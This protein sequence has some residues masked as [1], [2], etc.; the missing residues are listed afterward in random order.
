MDS[1]QQFA[2]CRYL[3]DRYPKKYKLIEL[4]SEY[5]LVQNISQFF[6][7]FKYQLELCSIKKD[8]HLIKW[9]S[10]KE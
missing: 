4:G 9:L 7:L 1:V 10:Q 8:S 3:V 5:I 6:G 2:S